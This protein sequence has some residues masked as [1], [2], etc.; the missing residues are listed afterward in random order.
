MPAFCH[1]RRCRCSIGAPIVE[2]VM[3]W[4]A[5]R[6][7]SLPPRR[8][9]LRPAHQ[10]S[11][12]ELLLDDRSDRPC[13]RR[14]PRCRK[15]RSAR[16][17][18]TG[19]AYLVLQ[20]F[21][22]TDRTARALAAFTALRPQLESLRQTTWRFLCFR[23]YAILRRARGLGNPPGCCGA[24]SSIAGLVLVV[25]PTTG[26]WVP[27]SLILS[28]HP[29]SPT[30]CR[31]R[32]EARDQPGLTVLV[33]GRLRR[34]GCRTPVMFSLSA[35]CAWWPRTSFGATGQR[36]CF[37]WPWVAIRF[38]DLVLVLAGHMDPAASTGYL[39]GAGR[40]GGSRR[41]HR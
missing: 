34:T 35:W 27:M 4:C 16:A 22:A 7:R 25:S 9:A 5:A 17:R 11:L 12:P 6:G 32:T 38:G 28:A 10:G 37:S 36:P 15:C 30:R 29:R 21:A 23:T 8:A 20:R 40:C 18:D 33:G 14:R 13:G 39:L 19:G 41:R 26:R 3:P 2:L 31:D 1:L 24:M